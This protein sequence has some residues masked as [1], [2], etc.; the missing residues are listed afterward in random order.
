MD[1]VVPLALTSYQAVRAHRAELRESLSALEKALAGPAPGRVE[2]WAERVHVALVELSAD[3]REHV[4]LTEGPEGLHRE[5]LTAVPRLAGAVARLGD[6]HVEFT[7]L[8]DDLLSRVSGHVHGDDVAYVRGMGVA[9]LG[10]LV[11]HRQ[12]GADLVYEAYEA[13]IGGET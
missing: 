10:R 9:L 13:D 1:P 3:L 6:E 2:A 12:A 8:V 4:E 7:R 11:G 5:V